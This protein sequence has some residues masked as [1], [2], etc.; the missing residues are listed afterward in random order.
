MQPIVVTT[1][2]DRLAFDRRTHRLLSLRPLAPPPQE[3]VASAPE[4]PVFALQCLDGE[5]E[6]RH[7]TSWQAASVTARVERDGEATVL[8]AEF[9]RIGGLD[10]DV[11]TRVRVSPEDSLSRWR[12][13]VRNGAGVDLVDLQYPY[14][15]C[16]YDLGGKRGAETIVLPEFYGR[17]IPAPSMAKLGPDHPPAWQ[18]NHQ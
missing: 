12:I 2:C 18:L 3:F 16:P 15:V 10:L 17:L 13:G 1:Q 4:H 11:T 5:R 8:T 6:Y 14:L 7:L 9:R